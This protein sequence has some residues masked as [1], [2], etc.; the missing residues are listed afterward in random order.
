MYAL[1][2]LKHDDAHGCRR[3]ALYGV[4]GNRRLLERV[5]AGQEHP[6]QWRVRLIDASGSLYAGTIPLKKAV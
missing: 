6:E 4:C 2:R 1:I 3:Y 5:R